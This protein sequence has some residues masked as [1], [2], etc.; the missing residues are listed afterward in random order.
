MELADCERRFRSAFA[1]AAI[2]MTMIDSKGVIVCANEALCRM[3]GYQEQELIQLHFTETLHPDDRELRREIFEKILAG[4]IGSFTN[5][6]RMLRKDGNVVWAR[7]SVTVPREW[8]G[9]PQVI[10]FVEDITERKEAENALRASEERFRIAAENGSDLIYEWDLGTGQVGVFGLQQQLLGDWPMPP[11]YEAWQ[12]LVHPEDLE[13][14]VP[15][16]VRHIQSGERYSGDFRI[17]GQSGKIYHYSNR[18]QAIGN[19]DGEP[20]K[21]VGLCTDIT[22]KK[23]AEEAVSQLAAIVQCSER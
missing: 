4:E 2:G 8:P 1:Q 16:L 3:T 10:V 11:T 12:P 9:P 5:E 17:V 15:E 21:W 22:E 13:R 18:G 6:R 19:A 20:Y 7:T 23:L 14:V